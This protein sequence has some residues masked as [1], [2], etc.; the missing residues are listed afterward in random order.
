MLYPIE[1]RAHNSGPAGFEPATI[2]LSPRSIPILTATRFLWQGSRDLHPVCRVES[3]VAYCIADY[4]FSSIC[5][6][7]R[8][9]E[10]CTLT[11]PIKSR[12]L[13]LFEL[14]T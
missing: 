14:R 5:I 1:L 9:G 13:P 7:G 12:L 2:S 4:P 8:S 6:N 10:T 3:T 11:L